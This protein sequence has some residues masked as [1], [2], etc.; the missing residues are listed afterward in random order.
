MRGIQRIRVTD[1]ESDIFK[2]YVQ[3]LYSHHIDDATHDSKKW[4]KMYGLDERFMEEVFQDDVLKLMMRDCTEKGQYPIGPRINTVYEGTPEGSAVSRLLVDLFV[5]VADKSW[6]KHRKF[7]EFMPL[8]FINDVM[9]ALVDQRTPRKNIE[10]D[11][12]QPWSRNQ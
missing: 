8:E 1:V 5:W 10:G 2:A 11:R 4:A 9:L 3:W 7:A 12:A 6:V